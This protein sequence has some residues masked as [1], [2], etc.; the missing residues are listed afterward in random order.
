MKHLFYILTLVLLTLASCESSLY[1]T[2]IYDD[3]Y[4]AK[5]KEEV[6]PSKT[7]SVSMMLQ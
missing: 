1:T 7:I 6:M 2:K 3:A 5:S 4:Y